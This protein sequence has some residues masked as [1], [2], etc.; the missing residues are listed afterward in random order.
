MEVKDIIGDLPS[1]GSNGRRRL[2][3]ITYAVL[4]HDAQIAPESYDPLSRYRAEAAYHIKKG[5]KRLGYTFKVAR[6]GQVYQCSPLEEI[7]YHAG[8]STYIRNSVGI[9][10]DGSFD[11]QNPSVAQMDAL[12]DL[13]DWLT[14]RRP[15]IP[16]LVRNK[17]KYHR[18][19]RFPPLSTFCPGPQVIDFVK[20]YRAKS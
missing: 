20:A 5:W 3:E 16:K 14:E 17:I 18:E 2:E 7:A 13:L 19:V 12:R 15:D 4:H 10:L 8:N 9:C 1:K 11:K 6:D